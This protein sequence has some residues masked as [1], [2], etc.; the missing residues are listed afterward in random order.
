M[1]SVLSPVSSE[2][3]KGTQDTF[4]GPSFPRGWGRSCWRSDER[5]F[6]PMVGM[7]QQAVL[8]HGDHPQPK[9]TSPSWLC[10]PRIATTAPKSTKP[11]GGINATSAQAERRPMAHV[12][13]SEPIQD[14]RGN[15]LDI[16][17]Q[18][19]HVS[20]MNTIRRRIE[21]KFA[22]SEMFQSR[23]THDHRRHRAGCTPPMPLKREG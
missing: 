18:A 22:L 16:E 21:V 17:A 8:G 1:T 4:P 23:T 19:K 3:P 9:Y 6:R 5:C 2:L 15:A 12:Q 7:G 10:H 11:C 20:Q 13:A 14:G